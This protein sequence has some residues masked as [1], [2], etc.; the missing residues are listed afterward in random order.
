MAK[1][2]IG[3]IY[4]ERGGDSSPVEYDRICKV[5]SV[6]GVGKT[7]ALEDVTTFCSEGD[8]E[9]IGGLA[10]GKTITVQANYIPDDTGLLALIADVD[11]ARTGPYRIVVAQT[12][13]GIAY[14]FDAVALDWELQPSVDSKN[15]VAF[16]FKISGPIEKVTPS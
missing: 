8:R 11:E 6:S 3:K 13:P 12:A 9:Y 14:Q 5:F 16:Q 15:I 2:F 4:F 7:N 10:D 1:G